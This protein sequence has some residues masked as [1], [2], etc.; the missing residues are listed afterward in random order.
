MPWYQKWFGAPYYRILYQHRDLD[1]A[2]RIVDNLMPHLQAGEHSRMLDIA[3]GEGRFSRRLAH[4]GHDVTGI[5]IAPEMV[6]SA[7]K[8]ENENLRFFIRDMRTPL[9]INYFDFAFNFFTSFGYFEKQEDNQLA[10][11]SIAASL[12]PGGVLVM[13]Y[14][15]AE[16]VL[17]HLVPSEQITRQDLL[18]D[19]RRS[20]Q[21]NHIIKDIY[22]T[23]NSGMSHSFQERV[24]VF[25][26]DD[27]RQMFGAAGMEIVTTF[28]DYELD[29][30]HR[31]N[32][33]R[34]IMLF[35]KEH[36]KSH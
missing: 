10:A 21:H 32:S 13:D 6:A 17:S 1:E 8:F 31:S 33:P 22:I 4:Y 12:K 3:C 20:Y 9:F 16:F 29:A 7:W 23:D 11:H 27:F 15:N 5:D 36:G 34:M 2:F 18:F 14:F 35:R 24:P 26:L 30:Y 28:G 19:I 25:S